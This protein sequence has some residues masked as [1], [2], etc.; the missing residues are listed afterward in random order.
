MR[1]RA[2]VVLCLLVAIVGVGCRQALAPNADTNLP[3]ET[4]ITA[5]PQ[6]TITMRDKDGKVIAPEIGKIPVRFHLYWAGSDADGAVVGFYY[7]VVETLPFD[8]NGFGI[9]PSLPGPKARDYHFTT[10]TDSFFIFNVSEETTTRQHA[11]FIYAVDDK[12]K[13]DATPARFIF[14]A[15]DRYPPLPIMGLAPP[16]P[17]SPDTGSKA[18][19]T[20]Y[21]IDAGGTLRA[22][23]KTYVIRDS[24]NRE[25]FPSDTVPTASELYF[26]WRAEPTLAGAYVTGYRYKLNEPL[27][28]PVD[29]SVHVK[30]YNTGV[31]NDAV[32]AGLSVFTLRALDQAG[33]KR[34]IT[35]RFQMNFSP[36]SW[37]AGPDPALFPLR[38]DGS[39]FLQVPNWNS[40]AGLPGTLLSLDSVNVLPALRPYRRTFFEIYKDRL[41]A[42]VENDTVRMNSWVVFPGGGLD[43]DSP[44]SVQVDN[45]D[46]NLTKHG[47]IRNTPVLTPANKPNGSPV[48]LTTQ[49]WTVLDPSHGI[50]RFA[51]ALP[52]PVFKPG[53]PYA[54]PVI[55]GYWGMFQSGKAYAVI[56]AVDGDG[57]SDGRITDMVAFANRIDT[58][59]GTADEV[60]LRTRI[61]TFYVNRSPILGRTS[62]RADTTICSSNFTLILPAT[63]EDPYDPGG[64]P[65]SVGGPS[66][67]V[68]LRRMLTLRGKNLADRDTA[69]TDPQQYY[70][71]IILNWTVPSFFK[72][73]RLILEVQLCD[74]PSCETNPGQG[75]C[76]VTQIPFNYKTPPCPEPARGEAAATNQRPGP[77]DVKMGSKWP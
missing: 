23:T 19:G 72:A 35:R 46:P 44:Y 67:S 61:I 2:G 30:N 76:V 38:P 68:V 43:P 31:G 28:V 54:N 73:G 64:L 48:A 74:C 6:D 51:S 22:T 24:L 37:F 15:D 41:Y 4:W 66:E 39:R 65:S 40:F 62:P 34:E 71:Q 32:P 56:R 45:L 10:R 25:T 13:A 9:L 33:G 55:N 36:D 53:V 77:T 47:D 5:A 17:A 70:T 58:F 16:A 63:D 52:Y 18:I 60:N 49:V 59:G 42:H 3:P 20:T 1:L 27:F 26:K 7:A 29:S 12:G 11:F 57:A 50:S 69:W 75:R 8:P 14:K 21:S